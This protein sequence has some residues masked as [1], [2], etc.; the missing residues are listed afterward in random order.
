M[1]ERTQISLE[2]EDHRRARQRAS[3]LGISLAE[4]IRRLIRR[5]LGEPRASAGIEA[6]F[7]LG[8]SADPTDVG[9]L[10]DE[11]VAE[12]VWEEYLRQTGAQE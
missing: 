3:Q 9:R 4:Y 1:M 6:I 2:R 7:N 8:S 10:K 12:A 11:Y 5:D